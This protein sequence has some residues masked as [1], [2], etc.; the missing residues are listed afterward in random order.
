MQNAESEANSSESWV[1][2]KM[3]APDRTTL[4]K[5]VNSVIP[6]G[7][8]ITSSF[9][10]GWW[11]IMW[12]YIQR[13]CLSFLNSMALNSSLYYIH[14][15]CCGFWTKCIGTVF[16]SII[17]KSS[18]WSPPCNKERLKKHMEIR[19]IRCELL[20]GYAPFSTTGRGRQSY[21]GIIYW[22]TKDATHF[23]SSW[24]VIWKGFYL[25]HIT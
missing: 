19:I 6:Q 20:S 17:R 23:K 5:P 24:Y 14:N 1:E 3:P 21:T 12:L 2:E 10:G 13:F 7:I 15:V 22:S 11:F 25:M 4:R 8:A 16:S 9:L 18:L